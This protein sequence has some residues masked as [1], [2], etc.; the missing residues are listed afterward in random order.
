MSDTTKFL[1]TE[2]RQLY[3]YLVARR[4]WELLVGW[5][6]LV[7]AMVPGP[8]L[9]IG[10]ATYYGDAGMTIAFAVI[11]IML[12][13]GMTYL[14]KAE[15]TYRVYRTITVAGESREA[16][17]LLGKG[18]G[19]KPMPIPME[20]GAR[21]QR[22]VRRVGLTVALAIAAVAGVALWI[23]RVQQ[24]D[25]DRAVAWAVA[26]A[27]AVYSAELR[28]HAAWDRTH[29]KWVRVPADSPRAIR[30]TGPNGRQAFAHTAIYNRISKWCEAH[31]DDNNAQFSFKCQGYLY[32]WHA[33]LY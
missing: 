5:G 20:V 7:L 1:T 11:G 4:L 18:P 9:G 19:P 31:W 10:A 3:R 24:N 27:K 13:V 22:N 26:E 25:H 17:R 29:P 23:A 14:Q 32:G 16:H 33:Y 28:D 30:W 15:K 8:W 2:E 6:L 12:W 21:I